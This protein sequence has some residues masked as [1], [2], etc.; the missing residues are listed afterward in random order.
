MLHKM[1]TIRGARIS[2]NKPVKSVTRKVFNLDPSWSIVGTCPQH[3]ENMAAIQVP[4]PGTKLQIQATMAKANG[5]MGAFLANTDSLSLV[6]I[7]SHS[8]IS[9]SGP[10]TIMVSLCFNC[11]MKIF[12]GIKIAIF[13]RLTTHLISGLVPCF[14]PL[15][16]SN[17][18]IFLLGCHCSSDFQLQ[19]AHA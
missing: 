16:E 14:V 15:F 9:P 6:E 10:L 3:R 2:C 1:P 7:I 4:K 5:K 11:K 12:K 18:Q 17:S 8:T 19:L 13:S